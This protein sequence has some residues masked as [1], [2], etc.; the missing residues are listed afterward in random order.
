MKSLTAALFILLPC[1]LLAGPECD[2]DLRLT[3]ATVLINESTQVIQQ[4]FTL[5]R[6]QNSPNGRCGVYRLFFGKGMANSYQRAAFQGS[7]QAKYNLHPQINAASVLKEIGDALSSQEYIQGS[8]PEKLTTYSGSFYVSVPALSAQGNLAPGIYSD[9]VQVAV[10]GLNPNSGNYLYDGITNLTVTLVVTNQIAISIVEEG[11]SFNPTSTS[12]VL[13]YGVLN[14]NQELGA[15]VLVQSNTPYQLRI[16]SPNGGAL[17]HETSSETIGY[18]LK[19][20]NTNVGLTGTQGS[21]VT[22]GGNTGATQTAGDRY[23]LK[24]KISE[25]TDSKISGQY[26]D[27]LT[28]TAIAN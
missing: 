5:E 8:A 11:A 26:Q 28:I 19:V 25:T 23:N 15:D 10:Y 16:S 3:N 13:D 6:G 12:R 24:I 20:N 18:Q 27:V 7:G 21:P 14:L 22:I 17:K 9:T 4:N 2:Y 1:I